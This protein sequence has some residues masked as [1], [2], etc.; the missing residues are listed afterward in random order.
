MCYVR[1]GMQC[2]AFVTLYYYSAKVNVNVRNKRILDRE[3]GKEE[4]WNTGRMYLGRPKLS[5][6]RIV[7]IYVS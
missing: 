1:I 3:C 2:V 4:D 7:V 6:S 5:S